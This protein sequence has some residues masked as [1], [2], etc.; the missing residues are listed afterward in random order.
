LGDR[1]AMLHA[2]NGV[3]GLRVAEE[4][5]PDLV[6]TD[7]MM[8]EKDGYALTA[9]LRA[10]MVTS[11]IP[12]IMLTAKTTMEERLE[13]LGTGADAYLNK[14]FDERLLLVRIK[15]LLDSRAMLRERYSRT[16]VTEGV[17]EAAGAGSPD[18]AFTGSLVA[19][20]SAHLDDADYFP[21]GL[22]ADL[23]LSESQLR[24]K[25]RA[26]TGESVSAFLMHL[27][28]DRAHHILS[29]GATVK[30]AAFACGFSD[31]AYFTRSFKN[32]FGIA[33]SQVAK[34]PGK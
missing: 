9:D 33:P 5:V 15:Q 1:Y 20:M 12:I 26:V 8:P 3:E 32:K 19:A 18:P 23:H 27:R 2:V 16:L 24:R 34:T 30:E 10:S 17:A 31:P 14:P 21:A 4:C 28:L 7:V 6:I 11:H 13:G 29:G 25:T 22:A